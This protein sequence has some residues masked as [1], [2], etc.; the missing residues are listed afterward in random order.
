MFKRRRVDV[1]I[2]IVLALV[3]LAIIKW[4]F[5]TEEPTAV[6]VEQQRMERALA[7]L[8][9][10]SFIPFKDGRMPWL[11]TRSH[12]SHL[13]VRRWLGDAEEQFPDSML[14]PG[15]AMPI[16]PDDPLWNAYARRFL[17]VNDLRR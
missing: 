2:A 14:A 3:S 7:D 16:R 6:N 11:V 4:Y 13:L 17:G 8:P 5:A 10:G 12:G 9:E 1:A 15:V